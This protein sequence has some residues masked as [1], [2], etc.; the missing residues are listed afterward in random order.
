MR[1]DLNVSKKLK[2][3]RKHSLERY[4]IITL[5]FIFNVICRIYRCTYIYGRPIIM[6]ICATVNGVRM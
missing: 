1:K 2:R 6:T 4:F 5:Y 3:P